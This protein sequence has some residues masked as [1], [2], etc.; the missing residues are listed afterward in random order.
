ML[1]V[2]S[3]LGQKLGRDIMWTVASF[4]ILAISGIIINFVITGARDAAALGIF[5]LTYAV[6][7]IASQIAT[8]GIHYSVLRQTTLLEHDSNE[9]G[10]MLATAACTALSLGAAVAISLELL[11]PVLVRIFDSSESALALR[12]A[13]WGLVLFPVT[14]VLIAFVNGARHMRAFSIF[15]ATRYIVV[16]A[17][18]AFI[19]LSGRLF[20]E[21]TLCFLVA[22]SV[23]ILSAS[24]YLIAKRELRRLRFSRGWV[25]EHLQFGSKSLFAGMFV[26]MNARIDVLLLG[27][28]LSDR[29]VGIY[30]FAAMLADGVYHLLAMIRVNFNPLLVAAMRDGRWDEPQRLLRLTKK[31]LP[32]GTAA[33]SGLLILS[34]Y[35]ISEYFL[36]SKGID[37]G[38]PSL[39]ILLAGITAISPFIPFDNLLLTSGFPTLQTVQQLVVF[40]VNAGLNLALVPIIGIEGAAIGTAVGYV[41][42]IIVLYRFACLKISWNLFKNT[43]DESAVTRAGGV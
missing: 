34:L 22:E 31:F 29:M 17:W 26:E 38:L 5:N 36:P 20:E 37:G 14:K 7:V 10:K 8:M 39:L 35:V 33:F 13:S 28:F 41:L 27:L 16:M 23:T 3:F 12:Y 11:S 15:Q 21:A 32:I 25:T 19:A 43:V 42:G 2:R 24:I 1:N 4:G 30:S 18:V 40:V 6:Y 9:R